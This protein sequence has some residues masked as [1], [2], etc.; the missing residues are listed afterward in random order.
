MSKRKWTDIPSQVDIK[1]Q[2][3]GSAAA[4][5]LQKYHIYYQVCNM[6]NRGQVAMTTR[7]ME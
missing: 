3:F 5:I 2:N 7:Y 6:E 4:S 1:L